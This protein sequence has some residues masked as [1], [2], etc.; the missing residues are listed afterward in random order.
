MALTLMISSANAAVIHGLPADAE[1]REDGTVVNSNNTELW[2]GNN[3]SGGSNG[4]A[5]VIPFQLPDLGNID[6]PFVAVNFKIGLL[7]ED[8]NTEDRDKPLRLSSLTPRTSD[9][10]LA[11]DWGFGAGNIQNVFAAPDIQENSSS[12][13]VM[14][15]TDASGDANLLAYLNT[16]YNN[17]MLSGGSGGTFVFLRLQTDDFF[18]FFANYELVSANN[19]DTAL[20]N[21]VIEYTAVP[22][23]S[24]MG[25]ALLGLTMLGMRRRT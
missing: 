5:V 3:P 18:S 6:N 23:P 11:S 16:S 25:L 10:V 9:T 7:E 17:S 8:F 21:P 13:P 14:L 4:Q 2:V 15:E 1:A 19:T 22:E 24:S 12:M 20:Q